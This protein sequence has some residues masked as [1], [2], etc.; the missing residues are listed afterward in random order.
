NP[1][2]RNEQ[3]RECR[4]GVVLVVVERELSTARTGKL[5]AENIRGDKLRGGAHAHAPPRE[6]EKKEEPLTRS[7]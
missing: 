6:G 7:L 5:G 4:E 3:G 1:G 2:E